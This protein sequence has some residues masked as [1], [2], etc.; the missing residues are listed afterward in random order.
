MGSL[1]GQQVNPGPP[2]NIFDQYA[3]EPQSTGSS[4]LN[5]IA[6]NVLQTGPG[7]YGGLIGTPGYGGPTSPDINSTI[8]PNV[9][10]NWQPWNAGTGYIA[11]RLSQP[12]AGQLNPAFQT[13]QSNMAQY[14]GIGGYPTQLLHGMAQYG[15]TGG[16]GNIGMANL[17]QFGAPSVAGQ[18][19]AN[20]AQT[21]VSGSWGNPL[22]S[23]AQGGASP[24][25]NY[26]M[27]FLHAQAY[28]SKRGA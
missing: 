2:I 1:L 17:L 19:I 10:G 8:L 28:N 9:Y 6:S 25:S 12:T 11:N 14:G 24:A 18:P 20:M 22:L 27:P 13:A 7:G 3:R 21:G 23:M 26:L 5:T 16:P 15:G 4:F